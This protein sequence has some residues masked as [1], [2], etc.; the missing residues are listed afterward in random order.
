MLVCILEMTTR[1][2]KRYNRPDHDERL[3]DRQV[4]SGGFFRSLKSCDGYV[5]LCKCL[6]E[7]NM[8][9]ARFQGCLTCVMRRSGIRAYLMHEPLPR[10]RHGRQYIVSVTP[11]V[12]SCPYTRSANCLET[13]LVYHCYE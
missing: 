12:F 10:C 1:S 13:R 8:T 11:L 4:C 9:S 3:L 7:C 6:Y 2:G 5:Y